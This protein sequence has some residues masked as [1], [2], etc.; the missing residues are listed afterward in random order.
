VKN[1]TRAGALLTSFSLIS[2]FWGCVSYGQT[3]AVPGNPTRPNSKTPLGG[4]FP[5][6]P[7]TL[8]SSREPIPRGRPEDGSED[9]PASKGIY[10]VAPGDVSV[11]KSSTL[12][13]YKT[14]SLFLINNPG[15]ITPQSSDKVKVLYV[16]FEA[17]GKVIGPDNLA[18][19]FASGS[20]SAK[21]FTEEPTANAYL[22]LDIDRSVAFCE[23]L[24]LPP[25]QGPYIL[26]TTEYPG[27]GLPAQPDTILPTALKNY[28]IV[29][30]YNASPDQITR[31]ITGVADQLTVGDVS[32]LNEQSE[33]YWRAWQ[34][35]FENVRDTLASM[36]ISLKIKTPFFESEVK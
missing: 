8:R 3:K 9:A 12:R 35:A 13:L 30:L 23:K 32:H 18:V 25:S 20:S 22:P 28:E 17:F 29:R 21:P 31:L 14:W 2:A 11:P 10:I 6:A 7:R 19:W 33:P 1:W 4:S 27:A 34:K 15:W 26:I 5:G 16:S 36:K 24:G